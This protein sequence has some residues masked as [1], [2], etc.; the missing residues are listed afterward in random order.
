M[1]AQ[2]LIVEDDPGLG[3]F[4]LRGLEAEGHG[5]QLLRRLGE[6]RPMR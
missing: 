3:R 2:L 1:S 5:C 6:A 4:L